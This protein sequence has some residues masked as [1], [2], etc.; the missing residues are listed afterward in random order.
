VNFPEVESDLRAD[1]GLASGKGPV[2]E[3][4]AGKSMKRM[5]EGTPLWPLLLALA[6][7]MA[8]IEGLVLTRVDK[9]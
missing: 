1:T 7:G 8:L 4:N 9:V 6:V 3:L 2:V 5:R